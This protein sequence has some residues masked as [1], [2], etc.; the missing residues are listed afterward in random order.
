MWSLGSIIPSYIFINGNT[1]FFG[2]STKAMASRKGDSVKLLGRIFL[3]GVGNPGILWI[4]VS[5]PSSFRGIIRS[6]NSSW[7]GATFTPA[8]T[9]EGVKSIIALFTIVR[10]CWFRE[11]S[12]TIRLVELT[13]G[14]MANEM[15]AGGMADELFF[16]GMVDL[17]D[18]GGM[19]DLK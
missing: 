8:F 5:M 18:L 19:V 14:G 7:V 11:P 16:G 17:I 13:A 10:D 9:M 3:I 15:T 2:I 6:I 4:M 12:G 1:I